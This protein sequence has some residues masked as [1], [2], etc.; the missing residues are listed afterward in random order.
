MAMGL[1]RAELSGASVD[2][3]QRRREIGRYEVDFAHA[4]RA[5]GVGWQAI[6][7]MLRVNEATLRGVAGEPG[8]TMAQIV[9]KKTDPPALGE[10]APRRS[11]GAPAKPPRDH[12]YVRVLRAIASGATHGASIAQRAKLEMGQ[13]YNAIAFLRGRG[14]VTPASGD[15]TAPATPRLTLAGLAEL[16][17]LR[18]MS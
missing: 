9:A 8:A 18:L 10:A 7:A 16:E 15:P 6:A 1:V 12:H 5:R 13:A 14:L 3:P 2:A 11:A 17:R 4:R